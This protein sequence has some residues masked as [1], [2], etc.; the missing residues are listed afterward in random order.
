MWVVEPAPDGKFVVSRAGKAY[1]VLAEGP[2]CNS[3][4]KGNQMRMN[5][6]SRREFF[7]YAAAA[8][9]ASALPASA[10]TKKDQTKNDTTRLPLV[11]DVFGPMAFQWSGSRFDVWMPDLGKSHEAGIMTPIVGFELPKGN[12]QISG[13]KG[14][15]GKPVT[16]HLSGNGQIYKTGTSDAPKQY[17]IH[18]SLPMPF[19]IGLL[20]PMP[21]KIWSNGNKPQTDT[22]YAVGLRLFYANAGAPTLSMVDGTALP[23]GP[24]SDGVIR[25]DPDQPPEV[26]VDM[27]ISYLPYDASVPNDDRNSFAAVA[28]LL[29]LDLQIE[30]P[31]HHQ[32][33][34]PHRPCRSPVLQLA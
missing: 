13:T 27:S 28:K 5:T 24:P 4:Y 34:T 3:P 2:Q 20:H 11:V 1:D 29:E 33:V 15:A 7:T 21:A 19:H 6:P 12:Y 32:E 25:F 31:A 26:Q 30:F 16:T 17:Y 9:L 14:F 18:L 23:L 8:T 22:L 10:Q